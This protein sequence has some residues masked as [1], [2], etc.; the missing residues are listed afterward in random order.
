MD[1][2]L[3]YPV[4]GIQY[5][6]TQRTR[7]KKKTLNARR[8]KCLKVIIE[9]K[10]APVLRLGLL[11]RRS[12][13]TWCSRAAVCRS[14]FLIRAGHDACLLVIADAFLKEIR[15]ACETDALHEIE[16]ILYF[17]VLAV[18]KRDEES[19]GY[20]FNVCLHQGRVHAEQAAGE[21]FGQELLFDGHGFGNDVLDGLSG[22]AVVQVRE[23]Q[24]GKVG[25]HAFVAGDELVA[26]GQ[27]RHQASFLKPEDR[28]KG[29][30]K[31]D[32]FDGSEGYQTLGEGRA[33]VGYP[34]ESP[35]GF[36]ADAGN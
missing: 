13:A 8:I 18:A 19:V 5:L 34:M 35:I 12:H 7:F 1:T 11:A 28:G 9:R 30:R 6:V 24:A 2:V 17:V 32:A 21:G 15:L 31:E 20:E 10:R 26:E 16:W 33:L 4:S 29:A 36:F 27:P 22:G 14:G 23:Q 25:V 3:P